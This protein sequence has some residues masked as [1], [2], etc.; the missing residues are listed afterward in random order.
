MLVIHYFYVPY[1]V[2]CIWNRDHAG[3]SCFQLSPQYP[4]ELVRLI[5]VIFRRLFVCIAV[6]YCMHI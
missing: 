1:F 5:P 3:F 4:P 6:L 2:L